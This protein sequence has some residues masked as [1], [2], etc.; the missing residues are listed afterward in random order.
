MDPNF[1]LAHITLGQAYVQKAMY[2]EALA[3]FQ[4]TV[5]APGF[6]GGPAFVGYALAVSGKR[7]DARRVL[8]QVKRS[9]PDLWAMAA[10]AT[11]L[12]DKDQAFAWLQ[13]AREDHFIIFASIKVDPVFDSLRSDPRFTE[14]LRSIGL[15]R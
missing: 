12:G 8:D 5:G 11:G 2:Q 9:P 10:L 15:E 14:L 6:P 3:E 13:K 7:G 1:W 4:K